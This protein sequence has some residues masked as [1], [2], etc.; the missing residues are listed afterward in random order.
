MGLSLATVL[1]SIFA[2]WI[3]LG[4][5]VRKTRKAFEKQLVRQGMTKK[6]ARRLSAHYKKMKD[7]IMS[8]LKG[9]FM[10]L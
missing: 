7:E 5:K 3:T 10:R 6:D 1:C 8:T 9:S 2:L 4:W